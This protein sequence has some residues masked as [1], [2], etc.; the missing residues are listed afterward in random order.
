MEERNN[1][2]E[3]IK[4]EIDQT[5]TKNLLVMIKIENS[6]NKEIMGR[7]DWEVKLK[8]KLLKFYPENGKFDHERTQNK[9]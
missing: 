6:A 5:Q 2:Y 4:D 1:L 3:Q 9:L 8:E 7:L